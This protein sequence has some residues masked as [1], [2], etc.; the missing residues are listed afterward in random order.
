MRGNI[1]WWLSTVFAVVLATSSG[2]SAG[3][4]ELA[5]SKRV[6]DEMGKSSQRACMAGKKISGEIDFVYHDSVAAGR[7]MNGNWLKF[8]PTEAPVTVPFEGIAIKS[9]NG[10]YIRG[11]VY[12][13]KCEEVEVVAQS[14]DVVAEAV[15]PDPVSPGEKNVVQ[16]VVASDQFP[17]VAAAPVVGPSG[18]GEDGL[19]WVEDLDKAQLGIDMMYSRKDPLF[20]NTSSEYYGFSGSTNLFRYEGI[21]FGFYG[22]GIFGSTDWSS[23]GTSGTSDWDIIGGG[24]RLKKK[25]PGD[26]KLEGDLG[27]F[28]QDTD[29]S[30]SD[31]SWSHQKDILLDARS[32][33]ADDS[34]RR[35]GKKVLPKSEYFIHG[36]LPLN[37]EYTDSRGRGDSYAYDNAWFH[38]GGEWDLYD[39]VVDDDGHF[40]LTPTAGA[41]IG[42]NYGKD[43]GLTRFGLGVDLAYDQIDVL[44]LGIGHENLSD[45]DDSIISFGKIK[46]GNLLNFW[47]A[48]KTKEI[49][50]E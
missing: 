39:F 2:S 41:R 37:T 40:R 3:P 21:D 18:K 32:S 12:V 16:E 7:D 29:G 48:K 13:S 38:L 44:E 5:I 31:G 42:Y 27:L 30:A 1:I 24:V 34:R 36:S 47:E 50:E 43:S 6:F 35:S 9:A 46:F 26:R 10:K 23:G 15:Q 17:A 22:R 25:L 20:G 8:I 28:F 33:L 14:A 19:V 49:S 45:G 4:R 11:K